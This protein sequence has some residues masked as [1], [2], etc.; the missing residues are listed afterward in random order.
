[1][2]TTI[3]VQARMGSS[4]FP[5]KILKP[6]LGEPV[7]FRQLERIR[8]ATSFDNL[9]VATTTRP[10]DD[11][12]AE[13]CKKRNYDVYRG[14]NENLLDRHFKAAQLYDTESVVKIPSDCPLI[15]PQVIDRVI[16][17]YQHKRFK[18]DFVSNLHPQ[19]YPDGNDVEIM[20]LD[21]LENAWKHAE[22]NFELEHTT[23]YIWDN[24]DKFRIGN[25]LWEKGIDLS[26]SHRF[27]ID[28]VEDYEF[29]NRVYEE[30]YPSYPDFSLNDILDL[31]SQKPEI[32]QINAKY[33]GV[34]WYRNHL[35]DLNTINENDTKVI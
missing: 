25:V 26:K 11:V 6:I 33:T 32:M 17:Y 16:G 1:M 12:I 28:Y 20:S 4:R 14:S 3:I 29:I 9:V 19:S 10:D 5:G 21:V 8:K 23:P 18:Y 15:D 24:P 7:L 30:L 22:K 13:E 27:T 35:D 31:L 2:K 34:N